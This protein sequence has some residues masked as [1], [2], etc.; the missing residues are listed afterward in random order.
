MRIFMIALSHTINPPSFERKKE[1]NLNKNEKILIDPRNSICTDSLFK[2][3]T[4]P[5]W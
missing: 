5:K 3:C 1:T 2:R 4:N